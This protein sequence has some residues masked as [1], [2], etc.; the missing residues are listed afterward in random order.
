PETGHVERCGLRYGNS[1]SP[2]GLKATDSAQYPTAVGHATRVD[3]WCP[4]RSFHSTRTAAG[5]LQ[6]G[7]RSNRDRGTAVLNRMLIPEHAGTPYSLPRGS[8]ADQPGSSLYGSGVAEIAQYGTQVQGQDQGPD[9][10]PVRK[11]DALGN[12]RARTQ[13]HDSGRSAGH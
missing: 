11:G 10:S 8:R 3:L 7:T 6:A 12:V 9:A 5:D 13:S 1:G 4:D 2:C